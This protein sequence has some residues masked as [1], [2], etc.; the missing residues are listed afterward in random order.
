MN[1]WKDL[2]SDTVFSISH[3]GGMLKGQS[4]KRSI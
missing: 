2:N 3:A 1:N 4:D